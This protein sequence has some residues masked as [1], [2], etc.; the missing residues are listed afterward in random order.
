MESKEESG[1]RINIFSLKTDGFL[2]WASFFAI[3]LVGYACYTWKLI[4]SSIWYDE[5]VEYWYSKVLFGEVP[6]GFGTTNMYER[7]CSTFQPPLYNV[8]M[9]FWLMLFD[10]SVYS[11]RL[12]GV[13][14]T[15]AGAIGIWFAIKFLANWKWASFGMFMFIFTQSIAFY[16][17]ECAEYNLMVCC[18][19][20]TIFFYV[21]LVETKSTFSMTGFFLFASLS[22]YSQYGAAFVAAGFYLSLFVL[23]IKEDR[24][25]L[26]NLIIASLIEL[27]VAV[28]PLIYFFLFRQLQLQGTLSIS[29][30]PI[31]EIG[32][33]M[34]AVYALYEQIGWCLAASLKSKAGC[35][36][37]LII[38]TEIVCT[39]IASFLKQ[40]TLK[41]MIFAFCVSWILY[42]VAVIHSYYAY[43][44]WS[45]NIKF[46]NKYG[47][48][49]S[50]VLIVILTYGMSVLY[51][52]I[53]RKNNTVMIKLIII[54][55]LCLL[56][57]Q[58]SKFE[59]RRIRVNWI[60]E[61]IGSATGKW[62]NVNNF[63]IP[64]YVHSRS[65]YA[66]RFYYN[67]NDCYDVSNEDKVFT[68]GPWIDNAN[69]SESD[70]IDKFTEIGVF[71]NDSFYYI[72]PSNV[73]FELV[74]KSILNKGYQFEMI[75]PGEETGVLYAYK[76]KKNG[77]N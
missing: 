25:T 11:F 13:L 67:H 63:A 44:N 58:Y 68:V 27:F 70:M 33:I 3:L 62:I 28:I 26:Y 35:W 12:A 76:W 9:H 42:Y 2:C 34:D 66:F 37:A 6:G 31:Y 54:V 74:K 72:G 45:G 23:F 20:W 36:G 52:W 47:L 24:K 46:G 15:L 71:N 17:M 57:L 1:M 21:R 39:I 22:V 10:F 60:K 61:D 50:P 65:D 73:T 43:N 16:A 77:M 41:Y 59:L 38:G 7:I 49:F 29:H 30:A 69:I 53:T 48:F 32:P 18:L 56:A 40:R 75:Y 5:A 19:S 55:P 14:T 51:K 64:T 4:Y 8:F